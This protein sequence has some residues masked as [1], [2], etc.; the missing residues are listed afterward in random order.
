MKERTI[1]EMNKKISI[2]AFALLLLIIVSFV[3]L[4]ANFI[5]FAHTNSTTILSITGS[6][7]TNTFAPDSTYIVFDRHNSY[8]IY[9]Q[10]D[11][12]L[13]QGNCTESFKNQYLMEGNS[14]TDGNV[15]LTEDGLY[16]IPSDASVTFFQRFSD[17]PIYIGSWAE[18][19]EIGS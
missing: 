15:I 17:I 4:C 13:E 6:Y 14:G 19:R 11:G 16:Y 5:Q 7:C 18:D 9:N 2:P 1:V 12:V 8:T 10:S 3:S